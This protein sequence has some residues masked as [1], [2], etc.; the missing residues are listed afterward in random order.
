MIASSLKVLPR[1]ASLLLFATVS[2]TVGC[3]IDTGADDEEVDEAAIDAELTSNTALARK[4][5][6]QARVYVQPGSTDT[7]IVST[8]RRQTQS[9]FGALREAN[10]GVNSRE[11]NAIN[12]TTFQKRTVTLVD[13]T[14]R[15]EMTEVTYTYT[16][17]AVVPKTM[18]RRSA[19]SLGLL[20]GY[21]Q[22][23][24]D[25]ILTECTSNDSHARE[26]ADSIWYVFN[27][28]LGQC[29]AA[30]TK[31]QQAI[32]TARRALTNPGDEV[33]KGEVERL[34]Q[35]VTMKLSASATNTR[36]APTPAPRIPSTIA[37][38]PAACR[39]A[40]SSSVWSTV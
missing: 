18:A 4:L 20:N 3:A 14:T 13:G 16:D 9:A 15:R 7:S 31:E 37:C 11:L 17:A 25:R 21:Y 5:E 35:P 22:S 23:Q 29:K 24:K 27:P 8:I 12:P 38:S 1:L 33:V 36:A 30:M 2:A 19:L 40:S 39:R 6:F 10:V 26:F 28:S 32:D 34:Y